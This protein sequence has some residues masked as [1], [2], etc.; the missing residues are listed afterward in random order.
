MNKK[1]FFFV[2]FIIK[3]QLGLCDSQ[4]I[5]FDDDGIKIDIKI[6]LKKSPCVIWYAITDYNNLEKFHSTLKKSEIK[7][8]S[9]NKFTILQVFRSY[10][11][12]FP[13][14]LKTQLLVKE[15]PRKFSL[16]ISQIN[17][18]FKK[19][20]STWSIEKQVETVLKINTIISLSK[21]KIILLSK[22]ML[23]VQHKKFV[24][25]LKNQLNNKKYEKFCSN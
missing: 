12:G 15:I 25:D 16:E 1:Y 21:I 24:N 14:N 23:I 13:L 6:V 17:G 10:I 2:V 18:G 9:G 8:S 19:Y 7:E 11:L 5:I 4:N 22:D 3:T 20:N